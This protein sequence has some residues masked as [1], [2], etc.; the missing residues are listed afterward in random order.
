M[1][2]ELLEQEKQLY[3]DLGCKDFNDFKKLY[4]TG[5]INGK[6]EDTKKQWL[7][8]HL[9]LL[10]G[11]YARMVVSGNQG[12]T[13]FERLMALS[14]IELEKFHVEGDVEKYKS[15][16]RDFLM[17]Q[18][19]GPL[20][21]EKIQHYNAKN[22]DITVY[23]ETTK[24]ENFIPKVADLFAEEASVKLSEEISLDMGDSIFKGLAYA[25]QQ[26][27]SK[28]GRQLEGTKKVTKRVSKWIVRLSFGRVKT[29]KQIDKIVKGVMKFLDTART[30]DLT[31]TGIEQWKA[32]DKN[33]S[34][35]NYIEKI[36]RDMCRSYFNTNPNYDFNANGNREQVIQGFFGELADYI[37]LKINI[38]KGQSYNIGGLQTFKIGGSGKKEQSSI[39]NILI[40]N[41]KQYGIQ[42]KNPFKTDQGFYKT[43]EK[44]Y[45]LD[46]SQSANYLYEEIFKFDQTDIENFQLLNLNINN[47]TNPADLYKDMKQF[48]YIYTDKFAR[49]AKEQIADDQFNGYMDD[50]LRS[51]KGAAINN[52]FYVLKGELMQSSYILQ[53]I[54]EQYNYFINAIDNKRKKNNNNLIITYNNDIPKNVIPVTDFPLLNNN[55][56]HPVYDIRYNEQYVHKDNQIE[57]DLAK[58]SIKTILQLEIPSINDIM[59]LKWERKR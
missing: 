45:V 42:V 57:A 46:N 43:Y 32:D 26:I 8:Y 5:N 53:G 6:I 49:L 41:G 30:Y 39:D 20:L 52:V 33:Y 54:I 24:E 17:E 19:D 55:P 7:A 11:E 25:F 18:K 3:K 15:K 58:T 50:N 51:L 47:T 12:R 28:S 2:D 27:Q 16:I 56:E 36:I 38:P 23:L 13:L 21:Q 35:H 44:K 4:E 9:H 29:S 31:D 40:V 37:R 34:V 22:K 10:S 1:L 48:L 14:A 59:K